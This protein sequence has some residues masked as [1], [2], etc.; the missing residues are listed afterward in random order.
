VRAIN[1]L[2]DTPQFHAVATRVLW[3]EPPDV[4]L[5]DVPRFMAY[6]FRYATHE[7]MQIL[8]TALSDDDLR[9]AL[10]HAPPGIIDARS[11]SYWHAILGTYPPPPQSQRVF[12]TALVK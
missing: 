9:F 6:A 7:D 10:E 8:R 1:S 11:W 5:R 2:P 3:F 12:T 4:A